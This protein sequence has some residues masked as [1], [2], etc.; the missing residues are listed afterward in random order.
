MGNVVPV[1]SLY[2]SSEMKAIQMCDFVEAFPPG[3]CAAYRLD[4]C[5][6]VGYEP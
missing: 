1:E 5:A 4:S 6:R 3:H 2:F